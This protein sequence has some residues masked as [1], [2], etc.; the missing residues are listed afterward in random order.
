MRIDP[1]AV[2]NKYRKSTGVDNEA[3]VKTGQNKLPREGQVIKGQVVDANQSGVKI[4]LSDGR[5]IPAK[6]NGDF[7]F[8]I[9]EQV[10]F[11]VKESAPDLLVLTPDLSGSEQMGNKLATILSSANLPNTEEN[12]AMVQLMLKNNMPVDAQSLNDMV[13]LQKQFPEASMKQL[14]FMVKHNIPVTA[15]SLN[16]LTMLENNEHALMRGIASLAEDISSAEAVT[17]N[18]QQILNTIS[19]DKAA[20]GFLKDVDNLVQKLNDGIRLPVNHTI[21]EGSDMAADKGVVQSTYIKG[22]QAN[23]TGSDQ[24]QVITESKVPVKEMLM[25]A[26]FEKL[27]SS[28]KA[29]TGVRLPDNITLNDMQ[30]L[31][32]E[33]ILSHDQLRDFSKQLKEQSTYHTIAKGLLMTESDLE[34]V[35]DLRNYF[36]RLH[37]KVSMLAENTTEIL[38]QG[39]NAVKEAANVKA[40][41]EFMS[42]INQDFNLIHLPMMLGDQLLNSELYVMNDRKSLK[43][44]S[45]SITAL[46]R[47]DLLNLGH[48]DIYVKKTSKN[49]DVTFYM[50]DEPQIQVMN[51]HVYKLHKLLRDKGFNTMGITVKPVEEAFDVTKDFLDSESDDDQMKRYTFDMRA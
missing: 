10:N 22:D 33:G 32:R 5:I 25:S 48:M 17:K 28:F 3:S 24:V 47:L 19:E 27:S 29:I 31:V 15:E 35:S 7:Q 4:K 11:I 14:V 2:Y 26:D 6:L 12:Q 45:D 8:S 1:S 34:N 39:G 41:V 30:A 50:T 9:G 49:V 43:K 23:A 18:E 40:S 13:R 16:Q 42:A 46:V 38:N 36:T 44:D 20:I 51:D 37:Q 21:V